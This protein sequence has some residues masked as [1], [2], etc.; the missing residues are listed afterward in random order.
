MAIPEPISNIAAPGAPTQAAP[1]ASAEAARVE[2]PS[3][4]GAKWRQLPRLAAMLFAL[5]VFGVAVYVIHAVM[6]HIRR[7]GFASAIDAIP[8]A[9]IAA[10]IGATIASYTALSLFDRVGLAYLGRRIAFWRSVPASFGAYAV[11]NTLGVSFLAGGALRARLYATWGL[12]AQEIAALSVVC[13]MTT[14]MGAG[15]L[16]AG[17]CLIEPYALGGLLSVS[18]L[19]V[20]LIGF[21]LFLALLGLFAASA[22]PGHRLKIGPP[23]PSCSM[24]C[25]P[26][27]PVSRL[28]FRFISA[29]I[30]PAS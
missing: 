10:A 27:V 9:A 28:S 29:P 6:S 21:V 15:A 12:S 23:P 11:G 3:P 13:E 25:C 26:R 7:H 14:W 4:L 16:I 5:A 8:P 18:P 24:F 2:S 19:G 30:S 17:A 1:S 22:A 20:T